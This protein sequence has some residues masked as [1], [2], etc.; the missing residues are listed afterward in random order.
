MRFTIANLDIWIN[1]IVN[2]QHPTCFTGDVMDATRLEIA[3]DQAKNVERAAN[4]RRW[5]E[6]TK[7]LVATN[8]GAGQ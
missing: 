5:S 7:R 8:I 4:G 3:Q 1:E 6:S 2:K